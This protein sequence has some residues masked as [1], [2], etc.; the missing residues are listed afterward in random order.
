MAASKCR[1]R[2]LERITELEDQVRMY[3]DEGL[4]LQNQIHTLK[5]EVID[6]NKTINQHR[7]SGCSINIIQSI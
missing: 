5:Q 1:Q 4:I 6:L 2:K 7:S 3:K